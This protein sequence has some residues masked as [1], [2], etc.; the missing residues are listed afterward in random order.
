MGDG[1]GN[2]N[3]I[4]FVCQNIYMWRKTGTDRMGYRYRTRLWSESRVRNQLADIG[5]RD[6]VHNFSGGSA[7]GKVSLV[8]E[9][10]RIIMYTR[11]LM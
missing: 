9:Y 5:I 7:S 4:P 6:D 3:R 11:R 1:L 8:Y 2:T 10:N